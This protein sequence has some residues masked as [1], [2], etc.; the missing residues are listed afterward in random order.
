MFPQ[1]S[2]PQWLK[3]R[4]TPLR[5][6]VKGR[7]IAYFAGCTG[8]YLFPETP[9]AVIEVLERNGIEVYFPE[10]KCCGMPSL[11]EGDGPLTLDFARFNIERLA[12]AVDAGYEIV[13]SCPTCGF[14]LKS[15]LAE[16]ACYADTYRE[17]V[18]RGGSCWANYQAGVRTVHRPWSFP[19]NPTLEKL[20]KD[21]G[22]FSSLDAEKRMKV[23]RRTYDLGEYLWDLHGKGELN[24]NFGPV[25]ARMAYYAP[26][27]LR[28]QKIGRPYFDL[29]RLV[30]GVSLE[31]IDGA[32]FCCGIAGIMGFK[33][34]FHETSVAM[35]SRLMAK[36][37]TL[38]PERLVC[39][40][41]SCRIQFNQLVPHRVFH[42][43][44]IL[45]ESYA[46]FTC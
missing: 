21:E 3:Q 5:R 37:R 10:Q 33:E 17:S 14:M 41:L 34:D 26:C 23:A 7:K 2:F 11:L 42:P 9:K 15:V 27:H 6:E 19:G 40:C 38:D 1:E 45:R 44:E 43:V 16:G 8:Q 35:G 4:S 13:C 12:E 36:V 22:Y 18:R 39:D 29:L 32:F 24:S 31:R 28:E 20:F 30:P 25:S 46:N